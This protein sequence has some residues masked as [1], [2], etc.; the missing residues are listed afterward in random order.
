MIEED[1]NV[2]ITKS[3]TSGILSEHDKG[4]LYLLEEEKG[5]IMKIEEECYLCYL[6]G[7]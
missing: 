4:Q 2:T 3:N 5:W 7:S 1:I 6:G